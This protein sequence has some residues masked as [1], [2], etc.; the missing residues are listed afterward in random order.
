MSNQQ[1]PAAG[2]TPAGVLIAIVAIVLPLVPLAFWLHGVIPMMPGP[3]Q[4]ASFGL[5]LLARAFALVGFVLMFYQFVLTSRLPFLETALKRATML[6]RHRAL[7]KTGFVLVLLHG[8]I[9][10]SLDPSL[11]TPKTLGLIALIILTV[12]VIAAW[13]FKPLKLKLKTWRAIHLAAY[14]V[15]PLVF[16]HAIA[17]GSTVLGYRPVYWLFVVLFT[18]YVLIVLYRIYRLFTRKKPGTKPAT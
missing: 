14:V 5:Y 9:L 6:K 17:L 13:F 15:F 4:S 11:Y 18:G 3:V 8:V 16:Y 7:G 1:K 10:L 12:A 2:R